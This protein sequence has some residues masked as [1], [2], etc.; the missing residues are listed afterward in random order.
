MTGTN[1]AVTL[2]EGLIGAIAMNAQSGLPGRKR[3]SDVLSIQDTFHKAVERSYLLSGE[4]VKQILQ[5]KSLPSGDSFA[6]YGFCLIKQGW[7]GKQRLWQIEQI[8]VNK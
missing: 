2:W 7:S 1:Q 6:A 4:Q 8:K 3:P 5:R